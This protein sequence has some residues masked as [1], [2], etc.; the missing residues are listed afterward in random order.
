MTCSNMGSQPR[1]LPGVG[2]SK[3]LVHELLGEQSGLDEFIDYK[4][5]VA[6]G[7]EEVAA[8]LLTRLGR[9]TTGGWW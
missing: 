3:T 4:C 8:E 2:S 1:P 7:K 9:E 6:V 5:W